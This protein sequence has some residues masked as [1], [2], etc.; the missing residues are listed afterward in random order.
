MTPRDGGA[1][2]PPAALSCELATLCFLMSLQLAIIVLG[3]WE[4]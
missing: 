2:T 4:E 3:T 1:E